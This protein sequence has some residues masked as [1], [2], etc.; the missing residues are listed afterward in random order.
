MIDTLAQWSTQLILAALILG[1][2]WFLGGVAYGAVRRAA[3]NR[4]FDASVAGFVAQL[5]RYTV[6]G[7]AVIASLGKVGIPVTSLVAVF[8]SAG[9]AIG[10]AL[11]G[12]LSSFASGVMILTFRPFTVDDVITAGGHT[13]KVVEIGLFATTLHTP[14]NMVIIVPNSGITGGSIVNITTLGT[15]RGT[16]EVG[17][18]YGND[19][20]KVMALLLEAASSVACVRDDPAPAVAFTGLGA[21]SLDFAVLT[22]CDS[23]DYLG[24]LHDVRRAVYNKLSEAEVEIPYNHLVVQHQP[25]NDA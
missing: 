8:A 22:W 7:A 9:L 20:D 13:G 2:G 10:M 17:V 23:A 16:V 12:N 14:D 19:V 4:K 11:Q 24:M 3:A 15:R 18:A 25:L 5:A 21:S 1:G 6:L